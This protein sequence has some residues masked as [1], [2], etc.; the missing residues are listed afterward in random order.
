MNNSRSQA[1]AP[2]APPAPPSYEDFVK[3]GESGGW[4]LSA[5]AADPAMRRA[6]LEAGA[7]EGWVSGSKL[8]KYCEKEG[9][10]E[11]KGGPGV[12]KRALA[13]AWDL[14]DVRQDSRGLSFDEFCVFMHLLCI[15]SA[16]GSLPSSLPP[17]LVPPTAEEEDDELIARALQDAYDDEEEGPPS[18]PRS[19]EV[20]IRDGDG[21]YRFDV[22]ALTDLVLAQG[23]GLLELD[24]TLFACDEAMENERWSPGSGFGSE[25]LLAT[26]VEKWSSEDGS[27]CSRDRSFVA[28][29]RDPE[30]WR[31]VAEWRVH[32]SAATDRYGWAYCRGLPSPLAPGAPFASSA[33]PFAGAV[34]RRRRWTRLYSRP[35][36]SAKPVTKST[37]IKHP[38]LLARLQDSFK[39]GVNELNRRLSGDQIRT[40]A[41]AAAAA[42][43][44]KPRDALVSSARE[45]WAGAKASKAA[46][47]A[48]LRAS[49]LV[50]SSDEERA[51]RVKD[52]VRS[53]AASLRKDRALQRDPQLFEDVLEELRAELFRGTTGILIS[54]CEAADLE[55][56]EKLRKLQPVTPQML[57]AVDVEHIEP[58]WPRAVDSI[59][60]IGDVHTPKRKVRKVRAALDDIIAC[61]AR[62][63]K[64]GED[65]PPGADDLLPLVILATLR[66]RTPSL[67]ANLKFVELYGDN[68][69]GEDGFLLTQ[70]AAAASFLQNV[71]A[72][73]LRGVNVDAFEALMRGDVQNFNTA[74]RN[75]Q[76]QDLLLFPTENHASSSSSSSSADGHRDLL[77][78]LQ[79]DDDDEEE[80]EEVKEEEVDLEAAAKD[81]SRS[82][83]L[84]SQASED[85]NS[86]KFT[87][88]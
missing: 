83:R 87:S 9:L 65:K 40:S 68:N 45:K 64:D 85:L 13:V 79:N 18:A 86:P 16:G 8:R 5:C 34:A 25:Y 80:K 53:E 42:A 28:P 26:D 59:R 1:S 6:F 43:G 78:L 56:A 51:S 4:A 24:R 81:S 19:S 57:D 20:T 31:L 2:P 74:L 52:F 32:I 66:A 69:I 72:T 11:T 54:E 41:A 70:I 67:L 47:Q 55:L 10:M 27:V 38:A 75:T 17:E 48:F 33:S 63:A 49:A 84:V 29:T 3:G 21:G 7:S 62:K 82:S 23:S 46:I 22:D 37:P 44:K 60:S 50:E 77:L 30:A 73:Q 15:A 12:P 36:V 14:A 71:D 35:L 61:L 39:S 58:H 88:L 76:E